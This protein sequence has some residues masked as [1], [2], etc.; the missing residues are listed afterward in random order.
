MQVVFV[1]KEQKLNPLTGQ[2]IPKETYEA[3]CIHV[4]LDLPNMYKTVKYYSDCGV[5]CFEKSKWK[6]LH[7]YL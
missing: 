1:T 3:N 2:M 6:I 5:N 7:V 4:L